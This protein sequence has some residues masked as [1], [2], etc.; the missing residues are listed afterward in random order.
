MIFLRKIPAEGPNR[1]IRKPDMETHVLVQG[2]INDV[3][4]EV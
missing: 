2:D 1:N 4:D 3:S